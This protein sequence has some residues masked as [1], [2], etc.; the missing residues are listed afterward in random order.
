MNS[1]ILVGKVG[2]PDFFNF[3]EQ[4]RLNAETV[5]NVLSG[6]LAG[7]IFRNI[8]PNE[9]CKKIS[10]NFWNN[11]ALK[12]RDDEVP[13]FYV[14]SY[15]YE[16]KLEEYLTECADTGER[17]FDL[18]RGTEN[19]FNQFIALL[20]SFLKENNITLRQAKH[21]G[22]KA[23]TFLM[24]SWCNSGSYVLKPHEDLSQCCNPDQKKFEIQET[25]NH[26]IVAVNICLENGEKGNLHYWN[27]QPD[28][29]SRKKLGLEITGYPYP[30][31]LLEQYKKL[32]IPIKSGDVYCFNGKN[33]HAVDELR[34]NDSKRSTISFLMGFKDK[35]TVIYWT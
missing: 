29:M 9:V 24:R 34:G 2:G 7:C 23:G 14:G 18:F 32:I 19:I 26:E 5:F 27:I 13:A 22:K 12:Q 21:N 30:E 20:G 3:K 35:N 8:I 6:K 17:I 11:S 15:H 16:K 33:I 31:P 28:L 4:G 25:V 10:N 1:D